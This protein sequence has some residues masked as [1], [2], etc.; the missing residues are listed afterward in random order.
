MKSKLVY[1][2]VNSIFD[3]LTRSERKI[4]QLV[5]DQPEAVIKMTAS[6]LAKASNTSPA[7]VIRF[8]KSIG[9]PSFPELKLMLSAEKDVPITMNYSDIS[10]DEKLGDVKT[11]LLGNA[12]QSMRET[13]ELVD[14]ELL[15]DVINLI[16]G[17]PFIYVYGIG[18]SYLVAENIAQKWNRIGKVCI[19]IADVHILISSLTSAPE[20]SVFIGIS[21]SG[22]TAEVLTLNEIAQ[23]HGLTT[24]GITEFG[25]NRLSKKV[26]VSLQTVKSKEAELRSAAT[27]SLMAQFILID[28]LF[29]AYVLQS[30]D[31][32]MENILISR[33][34]VDDYKRRTS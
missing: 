10:P 2:R 23:E 14:D 26:D 16:D 31:E 8:C 34:S 7:S 30:Y 24:I 15:S 3:D 20:K 29:H 28:L 33:K 13:I 12:Y 25:S 21:N 17:A 22:E 11:K 1:H 32:N 19:C 4:A 27:S 9:I 18:S 6:E 5:M